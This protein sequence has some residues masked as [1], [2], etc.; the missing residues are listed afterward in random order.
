MYKEMNTVQKKAI[1]Y[2]KF[3]IHLFHL[4]YFIF[5]KSQKHV[6]ITW[7]HVFE[8]KNQVQAYFAE[9]KWFIDQYSFVLLDILYRIS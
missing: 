5:I 8:L 3:C 7:M 1:G 2:L 6:E 4:L 9:A